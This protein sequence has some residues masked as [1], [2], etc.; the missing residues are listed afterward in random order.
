[1][2]GGVLFVDVARRCVCRRDLCSICNYHIPGSFVFR[3]LFAYVVTYHLIRIQSV[4]LLLDV[5]ACFLPF[6]SAIKAGTGSLVILCPC[7]CVRE[8]L[9][10]R[11]GE[12]RL[13]FFKWLSLYFIMCGFI[14]VCKRSGIPFTCY[15]CR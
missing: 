7:V 11:H 5:E 3:S 2:N 9:R 14:V 13:P 12:F 6:S 10:S 8:C 1:M 4:W 15:R